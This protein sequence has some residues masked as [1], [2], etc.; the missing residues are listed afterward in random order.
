MATSGTYSLATS[1]NE[2]LEESFD[3]LQ[4]G[5][6]GETLSG[7]MLQRGRRTLNFMLKA[8]EGQGLHLWVFETGTLFL[9]I[10]QNSYAFGDATT[11][12]ANDYNETTTDAVE[13]IGQ[14]EISVTSTTGFAVNDPI[15]VVTDDNDL[16]WS[17]IASFVANDTVTLNDA[18]LV[19]AAS[20]NVV[21]HYTL[22]SFKPVSRV[23]S[24]RRKETTDYEVPIKFL[25]KEDYEQ[26][27]NK[28]QNGTVIQTYYSR[29]Q[30]TGTMFVWNPPVSAIPVIRFSY[31]RQI[32][33][34]EEA[35][36]TFDLP[37]QWFECIAYNLAVRLIPKYGCTPQRSA[38]LKQLAME[39]LDVALGFDVANYPITVKMRQR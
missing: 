16:H 33:I 4:I 28:N 17:T 11:H 23:T 29:L 2:L 6:D 1:L 21:Y 19:A 15:G 34:M 32:Q 24:V 5:Q 27:P 26:L 12:L 10:G 38:E 25:S 36:N 9:T 13:A 31:E 3:L 18:L 20:G 39:S 35:A 7:D 30:P 22:D 14:T 8:W 37:E